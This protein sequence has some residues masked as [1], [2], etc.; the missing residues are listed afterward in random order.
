MTNWAEVPIWQVVSGGGS[1]IAAILVAA[2]VFGA[3]G[4]ATATVSISIGMATYCV[5]ALWRG[6]IRPADVVGT[7][8]V[9]GGMAAQAVVL[10]L[11]LSVASWMVLS[12]SAAVTGV[13]VAALMEAQRVSA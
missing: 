4:A 2:V 5:I 10:L 12:G 8:V 3:P 1:A 9:C 7:L 13:A 6:H 11:L